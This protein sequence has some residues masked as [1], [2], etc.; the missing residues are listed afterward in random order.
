MLLKVVRKGFMEVA[1]FLMRLEVRTLQE[2]MKWK[3]LAELQV[4]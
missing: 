2:K 1:M 3:V 4:T